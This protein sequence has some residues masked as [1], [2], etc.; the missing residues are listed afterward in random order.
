[1]SR[2]SDAL[3][4]CA[5]LVSALNIE[6]DWR[7]SQDQER[8]YITALVAHIPE[9]WDEP[10]LRRLIENYHKDQRL[11]ASLQDRLHPNH[12]SA[13]ARQRD[14]IAPI[15]RHA[16]LE[17]RDLPAVSLEDLV[18]VALQGLMNTIGSF[19]FRSR[20]STWTH[21]VII[22]SGRHYLR[23]LRAAK[24]NGDQVPLD[25]SGASHFVDPASTHTEAAVSGRAL[26]ELIETTLTEAGGK[27]MAYIF[28][29]W[30]VQDRRL[31]DI[32]QEVG[33]SPSRVSV[34]IE[35]ARRI[36]QEHPSIRDWKEDTA[37]TDTSSSDS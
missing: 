10:T 15:L 18:Q 1:M 26:A 36:L 29:L 9:D 24:R 25:R 13:W 33:L 37:D 11:V 6:R 28:H 31:V 27:R 20:F 22:R 30:A 19:H 8:A 35:Q 21:T 7:L 3:G 4:A 23:E 16:G 34:L 5:R 2:G 32:G 14:Q 12:Q 17:P